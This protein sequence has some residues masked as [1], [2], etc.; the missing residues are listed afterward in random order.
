MTPRILPAAMAACAL[1]TG[2]AACGSDDSNSSASSGGTSTS[3]AS[4]VKATLNG[5]GSTFAAPIYQQVGADLKDK[6][7]T[8]NYQGVGSGAGVS[9]FAAGTVDF[10]GSDPALADADKAAIN[11]GEPIQI[12]F[13]LGAITASY[14]VSGVDTGLKLDG[15]TLAKIYL[16]KI[17]SWDDAAIKAQNPD[18]TLPSTKITVIHRSDSSGTTKGF[19]QFLANYSPEWKGGPGVDKDIKWPTGTGAKGNDGVAAAV[20]QTDGAIGYVE[21]AYALQ[22]GFTFADVKNKSGAYVAP[23]LESTSAAAEGIDIP[24]DLGV[25][26]IDAPGAAAYPI[27]S[28]TFAIAYKDGCKAGLDKDKATG[29]KTFFNYLLNDGQATIKKLSYAP[30]PDSLKAKDQAVVDAMQCNGAAIGS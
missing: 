26:T 16:G 6:G 21:Q 22:N 15:A 19:T 11:K 28:Q 1:A 17:T 23:T 13:A 24:A 27:V 20:K 25:S 5:A 7:L 30:I 10:A 2:L 9:Q 18:A 29:L 8:I 14:K 12:P 3:T 4:T